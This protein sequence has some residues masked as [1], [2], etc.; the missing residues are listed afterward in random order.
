MPVLWIAINYRM[1]GFGFLAATDLLQEDN[2][3][4]GL[5]DQQL[6]L[7]WV[8]EHVFAFGGDSHKVVILG[9]SSGAANVWAQ[10]ARAKPRSKSLFH[11]AVLQSGS[12]GCLYPHGTPRL[13]KVLGCKADLDMQVESTE[14]FEPA[15]HDLLERT[16]YAS[17]KACALLKPLI[18]RSDMT[19]M[20]TLCRTF[21]MSLSIHCQQSSTLRQGRKAGSNL[22][23]TRLALYVT[24]T[25]SKIQSGDLSMVT[26]YRLFQW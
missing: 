10:V 15:F 8:Q 4:L 23:V 9:E 12:P 11:G 18:L 19:T 22:T 3:N 16:G 17:N 7:E 2:V 13:V 5:Y 25:G 26:A 14:L 6:A 21:E 24:D 20:Q 1:N